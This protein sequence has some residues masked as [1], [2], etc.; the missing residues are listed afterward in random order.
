M[1]ESSLFRSSGSS[2][3]SSGKPTAT[4]TGNSGSN[5]N[6]NTAGGS[7]SNSHSYVPG[8]GS[9]RSYLS[10][11]AHQQIPSS[12][13]VDSGRARPY[14]EHGQ[15]Q[16]HT[17]QPLKRARGR[18]AD[19]SSAVSVRSSDGNASHHD[20][21]QSHGHSG[22]HGHTMR[23][24]TS[25]I[26]QAVA[27]G[28]QGHASHASHG[29]AHMHTRPYTT[30]SAVSGARQAGVSP[31]QAYGSRSA[32]TRQVYSAGH[33]AQYA[34][35]GHGHGNHAAHYSTGGHGNYLQ[36][37]NGEAGGSRNTLE[38]SLVTVPT[39]HRITGA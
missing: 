20:L 36:K 6:S 12:T 24:T 16:G 3:V 33:A 10:S 8:G 31:Y 9:G 14:V 35:G 2:S 4:S 1:Y 11:T 13:A 22:V 23:S 21:G 37:A 25:G 26:S 15:G 39:P 38:R 7:N 5:S 30:S 34:T 17:T 32:A 28:N 18:T 29:H 27:R 19:D